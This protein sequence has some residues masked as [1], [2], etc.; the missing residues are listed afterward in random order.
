MSV[1]STV[2]VVVSAWAVAL[3]L[4]GCEPDE[5]AVFINARSMGDIGVLEVAALR[6]GGGLIGRIG[7]SFVGRARSSINAEEPIK[8]AI[9]LNGPEAI[10]VHIRGCSG[11]VCNDSDLVFVATRCY[12]VTGVMDDEVILYGP[13]SDAQDRDGDGFPADPIAT[14]IDPRPGALD[15][16]DS[17]ETCRY[18]CS[19]PTLDC[20]GCLTDDPTCTRMN[21][22][23]MSTPPGNTIHPGAVDFCEDGVDQD[24]DGADP[25]CRDADGDSWSECRSSDAPGTCDCNDSNA[26][27]HP[28]AMESPED[29]RTGL[30]R[31]CDGLP[32][33]CDDD[34]DFFPPC[35]LV[36]TGSCDC[37]DHDVTINPDADEVCEPI[38]QPPKDNDCDGLFDEL[39]TCRPDDLDGDGV[40]RCSAGVTTGCDCNDCDS[41]I[42]PGATE[43]C[44][45]TV[46]EDCDGTVVPCGAND[47]DHDGQSSAATGGTDCDDM[48][49]MRYYSAPERCGD[50]VDQSCTGDVACGSGDADSDTYAAGVDCDDARA[51]VRPF[52]AEVCNGRDDDCDGAQDEVLSP[53]TTMSLPQGDRGCT[54]ALRDRRTAS[55]LPAACAGGACD[56]DFRANVLHCG[57][58][59][60]ECN[61]DG[62]NAADI[63]ADGVCDCEFEPGIG[64]CAG[65][66]PATCCVSDGTVAS[67]GCKDL[68]SDIDNCGRC[69][70]HCLGPS[71]VARPLANVCTAST[72]RCGA[73]PSL[74]VAD[75]MDLT[76]PRACCGGAVVQVNTDNSNC[77]SCGNVCGPRSTCISGRCQCDGVYSDCNGSISSTDRSSDGCETDPTNGDLAHCGMAGTCGAPCSRANASAQCVAST[78]SIRACNPLYDDCNGADGDGC[79]TPLTTLTDCGACRVGCSRASASA[80]CATGACRIDRC[81]TNFD[82]CDGDDGNGCETPL[83]TLT[84][85]GGCRVPCSRANAV[86]TCGTASCRIQSC[87]PGY[88]NCNGVDSDGC[89]NG[90][91]SLADCGACR[92]TCDVPHASESCGTRSCVQVT[93]DVGW[94]D[95]GAGAGCETP[96]GSEGQCNCGAGAVCTGAASFCP[97]PA[98]SCTPCSGASRDCN[99]TG[100]DCET[101]TGTE[102]QCSC[103]AVCTGAASFCPGTDMPCTA[104]SGAMR[105]CNDTG[106]DCETMTGTESRC[107]CSAVCTGT[108]S[109][110][111]GT[112]MPCTA[113]SGA[114]RD[115]NDTGRDCETMT[116]TESQC[117]CSAVCTGTASFCPGTDM[118]CTACS[119][120][121][122]DC[123][124]TGRDCETTVGSEANCSCTDSCTGAASFCP[125]TDMPCTAC[126]GVMRDC[127]DTGRDCETPINTT[128]N[129]GGCGVMCRPAETC[130]GAVCQCNGGAACTGSNT[131]CAGAGCF[132][133]MTDMM[134]CGACTGGAA[135]CNTSKA[136]NCSGGTCRC[137]AAPACTG[138]LNCTSGVCV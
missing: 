110:C 111:P 12:N 53:V 91:S 116:G 102:S 82:T 80:T 47:S 97:G 48:D 86:A 20:D 16:I 8:I 106:R 89:E 125:G 62:V 1:R 59:G 18:A 22:D 121:T 54:I 9:V 73:A 14:C 49:P 127:N 120:A 35:G 68:T 30:D 119:G 132:N 32:P 135:T 7:P 79:E 27:I 56:L 133:L 13:L 60:I 2:L 70:T 26:G 77:G 109:F 122:R 114:M 29:C 46:D 81:N 25:L 10:V 99:D 126:S 6:P 21:D 58:C 72:C 42:H 78:C 90:L 124:D 40:N 52:A 74:T 50:G 75:I 33:Q 43:V 130:T 76:N 123:N 115:C 19:S 84:D 17:P 39:P 95:C 113:C 34:G 112:D 37:D 128:S 101:T 134:H 98:M 36:V 4:T 85:C 96:L 65:G 138:G 104:C 118:P 61:V 131:C 69:N 57:G 103:S 108:A 24:C 107:S 63:C 94:G 88:D 87:S 31:N 137:G 117:S 11:A 67:G 3:T 51:E 92:S 28:E 71:P 83:T 44:G 105:D 64:A 129:C 5:Y 23:M 38:D 66:M 136:D 15:P 41:G 100:R 45:N 55:L 93:C